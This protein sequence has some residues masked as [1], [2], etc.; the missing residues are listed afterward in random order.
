VRVPLIIVVLVALVVGVFAFQNNEVITVR[1]LNYAW[2][3]SQSIVIIA[4]VVAGFAAGLIV[5][6]PGSFKRWRKAKSL[7]K[8]V[9]TLRRELETVKRGSEEAKKGDEQV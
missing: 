4:S 7:E 6:L 1:F 3:T 2:M 8:E 9:G 5:M